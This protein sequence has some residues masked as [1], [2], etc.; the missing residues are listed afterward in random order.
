MLYHRLRL[1]LAFVSDGIW[2]M[3]GLIFSASALINNTWLP[4]LIVCIFVAVHT[5]N[6]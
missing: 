5:S 2:A 3:F 1:D 6:N 4:Q